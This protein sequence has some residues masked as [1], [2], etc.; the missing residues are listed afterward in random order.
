MIV[1]YEAVGANTVTY[2]KPINRNMYRNLFTGLC[3]L[4]DKIFALGT[5]KR[6]H[7]EM[8]IYLYPSFCPF[9]AYTYIYVAYVCLQCCSA[10]A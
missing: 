1:R 5:A 9:Y 4:V 2:D 10:C 8:S 6:E 3:Y 7:N